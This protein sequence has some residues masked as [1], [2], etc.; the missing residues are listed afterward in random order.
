MHHRL[1]D[2]A[3]LGFGLARHLLRHRQRGGIGGEFAVVGALAA[4]G[5]GNLVVLGAH[6]VERNAPLGRRGLPQH[7]PCR[8]AC[9]PQTVVV[10]QDAARAVGV[11]VAVLG[12]ARRLGELDAAPVGIELVRH[13]LGD[14]GANAL[15][16]L[17]AVRGDRNGAIGGE[18]DEEVR[19]ERRGD[20]AV[21]QV[22]ARRQ[23]RAEN[24]DAGTLEEV[25][26]GNVGDVHAASSSLPFD[27]AS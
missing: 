8:C 14:G 7:Q 18:G 9:I 12:V 13:H 3:M 10:H 6:F 25:S 2:E 19:L 24:K 21:R 11:L 27:M 1:A 22:G 17:R 20:A 5:V 16:H 23:C 4:A 15:T 26:A